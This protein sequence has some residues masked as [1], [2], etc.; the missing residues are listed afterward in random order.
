MDVRAKGHLSQVAPGVHGSVSLEELSGFEAATEGMLDFSVSTNPFGPPPPV[1][2]ALKAVDIS[3]Y[4]DQRAGH[5]RRAIAEKYNVSAAN[6][7]AGNGSSEFILLAALAYLSPG[8]VAYVVG[9]TYGEYERAS[10][11]MGAEAKSYTAKAQDGFMVDMDAV[12]QEIGTIK[13]KAVFICNPNNPTGQ[14][15]DP[16][17]ILKLAAQFDDTLLIIDE[18]YISF[19]VNGESC[20]GKGIRDNL[21]VLR[22]MT[23]D[24]ALA[25]L[26]LGYALGCEDVIAALSRVAPPWSVNSMAQAAG[27]AALEDTEYLERSIEGIAEAKEYL[28]NALLSAGLQVYPSAANF[29]LVEV[30]EA[31]EV[32]SRLMSKGICVRD[33]SSFG[34][35]QFIRIGV[36][37]MPEC[38]KLVEAMVDV[39]AEG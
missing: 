23:K 8:D 13:P 28:C 9:P 19:T 4:P 24:Y 21:L 27:I 33:C 22:S 2:E 37:T 6:V 36:R 35:P 15:T 18:A 32:R 34:L 31:S 5:L 12:A 11:I 20:I 29:F 38:R 30:G 1:L 14:Y 17:Q 26:R 7:W 25:G 16:D 10:Q 39:L 3:L